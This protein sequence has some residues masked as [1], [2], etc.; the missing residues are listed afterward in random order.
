MLPLRQPRAPP[1]LGLGRVCSAGRG[2]NCTR[3]PTSSPQLLRKKVPPISSPLQHRLCPWRSRPYVMPSCWKIGCFK[4]EPVLV[5]VREP[6]RNC[7][8][9]H[10]AA[11]W[12]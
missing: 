11:P 9:P 2:E 6:G 8:H 1:S 5:Q 12:Q 4:L 10:G 7:I 3:E